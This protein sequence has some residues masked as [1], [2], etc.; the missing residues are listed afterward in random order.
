MAPRARAPY[1]GPE[2]TGPQ[3]PLSQVRGGQALYPQVSAEPG[4]GVATAAPPLAPAAPPAQSGGPRLGGAREEGGTRAPD[5]AHE[6]SGP[7]GD[8]PGE[9]YGAYGHIVDLSVEMGKAAMPNP[10]GGFIKDPLRRSD[11]PGPALGAGAHG[12]PGE[13]PVRMQHVPIVV[14]RA[15]LKQGGTIRIILD[16]RLEG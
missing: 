14:T 13:T 16:L 5:V 9:E 3:A 2:P 8:G 4:F 1:Y 6:E 12:T 11:K 15:E 10:P 7:S